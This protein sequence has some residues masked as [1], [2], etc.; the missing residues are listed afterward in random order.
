MEN[1]RALRLPWA[2][3]LK[4]QKDL[5]LPALTRPRGCRRFLGVAWAV[6]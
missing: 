2:K 6:G 4:A 3:R 5:A 1:T